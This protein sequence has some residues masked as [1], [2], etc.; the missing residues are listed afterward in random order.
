MTRRPDHLVSIP[1]SDEEE[2]HV[3]LHVRPSGPVSQI[4]DA[5]LEATEGVA[6]YA[7]VLRHNRFDEALSQN[8]PC[9]SEEW[10]QILLFLLFGKGSIDN[11]D[12]TA[13]VT[14]QESI[15]ITIRRRVQNITQRL[16]T[17]CLAYD[18]DVSI[19][20]FD[21]CVDALDG[22]TRA[23]S[24]LAK[25]AAERTALQATVDDLQAQL[26]E[27]LKIKTADEAA[28][29]EKFC[30]LLNE[31]KAKI[32][33]LQRQ[34]SNAGRTDED[35][36]K[37]AQVEAEIK[38]EEDLDEDEPA[39]VAAPATRGR[40]GGVR[41]S[42][43]GNVG[44]GAKSA[45]TTTAKRGSKR[46]AAAAASDSDE[47]DSDVGDFEKPASTR[48]R[49]KSSAR[50]KAQDA[51]VTE[52][53]KEPAEDSGTQSD[54]DDR[55]TE[56]DNGTTEGE[57][58]E[59]EAVQEDVDLRGKEKSSRSTAAPVPEEAP[60]PRRTLAFGKARGAAV[61]STDSTVSAFP[62]TESKAHNLARSDTES[63]D[64]L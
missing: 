61:G 41:V 24:D 2:S 27:F 30:L 64:E 39:P 18:E 32:R 3:L 34:L 28:L 1:R 56:N 14:E 45:T 51:K 37:R 20:L 22:R 4:P 58:E 49:G 13:T 16:G 5:F 57:E 15:T 17:I 46:R 54:E 8:A 25:A 50:Q 19:E 59:P 29:L 63:D 33:Q 35:S 7:F 48:T 21:W 23:A 31:K 12:A 53:Q 62:V 10:E 43:L 44:R 47:A 11:V 26:D 40:R 55:T 36:A 6:P 42:R 60:P 38:E 52:A 9:T